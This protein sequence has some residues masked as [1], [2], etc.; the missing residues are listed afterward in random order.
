MGF[1][2]TSNIDAV[3][4]R[5]EA[6]ASRQLPFALSRALNDTAE[7][8][9]KAE[10]A[11]MKAV[12]DRPTPFTLNAFQIK[13]STK[14][15]L[16][17]VVEEKQN[18]RKRDYLRRQADGGARGMKGFERAITT[19]G[20]AAYGTTAIVALIPGSGAEMDQYGNQN[21]GQIVAVMAALRAMRDAADNT[22]RISASQ[23]RIERE[24]KRRAKLLG[25]AY[26]SPDAA[27]YEDRIAKAE[28]AGRQYF[29]PKEGSRLKPA[30]Y[31]RDIGGQLQV[32]MA[33]S[34]RAP[35]Y[36]ARFP[37][38]DTART[39]AEAMFPDNL[40][41]RFVEAMATAR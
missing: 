8:V 13:P 25:L 33:F 7:D 31:S 18:H 16:S 20:R 21:R 35:N 1:T 3:M 36:A 23:K 14:A 4:N 26:K 37:F 24:R 38:E 40:S 34:S 12:F 15:S 10:I 22:S 9:R 29:V 28:R 11:K 30:I 19:R 17:A 39:T 2:L 5:F 6:V 41:R 27:D 32:I